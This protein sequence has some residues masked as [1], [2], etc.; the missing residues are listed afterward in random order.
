MKKFQ[1]Y[2]KIISHSI[3]QID[4]KDFKKEYRLLNKTHDLIW[5]EITPRTVTYKWEYVQKGILTSAL[6]GARKPLEEQLK[7]KDA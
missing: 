1:K 7:P 2:H 6:Y 5:E 4:Y 3:Y